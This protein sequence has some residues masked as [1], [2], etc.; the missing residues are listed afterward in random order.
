V[1]GRDVFIDEAVNAAVWPTRTAALAALDSVR[2]RSQFYAERSTAHEAHYQA[3]RDQNE[4]NARDDD[5]ARAYRR[6]WGEDPP[7][8]A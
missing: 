4:R 1:S 6:M 8:V 5:A 3:E 7:V 2:D